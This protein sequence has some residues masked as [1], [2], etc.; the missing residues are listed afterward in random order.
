MS[1]LGEYI[2]AA[3]AGGIICGT[4]AAIG[5][6][7]FNP[8]SKM[9]V[10]KGGII[11]GFL[12]GLR[13]KDCEKEIIADLIKDADKET[14]IKFINKDTLGEIIKSLDPNITKETLTEIVNNDELIH[15]IIKTAANQ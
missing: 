5:S 15:Q 10:I 7:I 12:I 11:S 13:I 6:L 14:L 9:D 2:A 4:A 3:C 1:T 8:E